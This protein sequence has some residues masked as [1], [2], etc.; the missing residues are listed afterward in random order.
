MS[1]LRLRWLPAC[2]AAALATTAHAQP[3]PGDVVLSTASHILS[4][5]WGMAQVTT[6]KQVPWTAT[7]VQDRNVG[8]IGTA[9]DE[10]HRLTIAGTLSTVARLPDGAVARAIATDQTVNAYVFGTHKGIY[11]VAGTTVTTLTTLIKPNAIC[12]DRNTGHYVAASLFG[13]IWTVDAVTGAITTV[14]TDVPDVT[15]LAYLPSIRGFVVGRSSASDGVL[16]LDSNFNTVKTF[17]VADVSAVT[18]DERIN[19]IWTISGAPTRA[20]TRIAPQGAIEGSIP[21]PTY[22]YTGIAVWQSRTVSV[23]TTGLPGSTANFHIRFPNAST[24]PYC[25]ALSL[26]AGPGLDLPGSQYLGLAPDGLFLM[27]A[28]QSIPGLTARFAGNL[29][30][31]GALAALTIPAAAP[32]GLVVHVSAVMIDPGAPGGV[33]AGNA[34]SLQIR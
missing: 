34:D 30:F 28:C 32:P 2:F 7:V 24:E 1:T 11:R 31:G 15:G 14:R 23:A 19:R 21:M 9:N 33:V 5:D 17:N 8:L 18:V 16:L 12:R 4:V 10:I 29:A 25:V 22:A 26:A 6:L 3:A 27:T 13:A 20:V